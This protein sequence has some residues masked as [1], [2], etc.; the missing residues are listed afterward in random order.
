MPHLAWEYNP[1]QSTILHCQN[2][3]IRELLERLGDLFPEVSDWGAYISF[4]NLR[5]W[6][7]LPDRGHVMEEIYLHDKLMIIDDRTVL[8]GSANVNDRSLLGTRDSEVAVLLH[9]A[10]TVR[11]TMD[12]EEWEAG[13]FAHTLRCRLWREHLGLAE[14]GGGGERKGLKPDVV[15]DPVGLGFETWR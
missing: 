7:R 5:A 15:E 3:T 9:D 11:T 2:E 1:V 14:E 8:L 4:Y 13:S 10:D 6:G 12:G